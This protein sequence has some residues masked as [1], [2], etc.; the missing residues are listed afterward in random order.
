MGEGSRLQVGGALVGVGSVEMAVVV[1][2]RQIGLD[3]AIQQFFGG[4]SMILKWKSVLR[5]DS[6]KFTK[7]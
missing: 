1:H 2:V 3:I 7:N 4:V 5:N 6:T